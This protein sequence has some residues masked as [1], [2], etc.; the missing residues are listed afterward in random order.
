M[1]SFLNL[2]AEKTDKFINISKKINVS[3]EKTE[4]F[5][6]EE[7]Y[8]LEESYKRFVFEAR[9]VIFEWKD[10]YAQG[11]YKKH[12][13]CWNDI[14]VYKELAELYIKEEKLYLAALTY[15][16]AGLHE[17]YNKVKDLRNNTKDNEFAILA[18]R[19][20]EKYKKKYK[21]KKA[22]ANTMMSLGPIIAGVGFG[23]LIH[24]L[25]G[26]TNSKIAQFSL[27]L[28]GFSIL[29]GGTVVNLSAINSLDTSLSYRRISEEYK[30][31]NGTLPSEYYLYSGFDRET[32]KI[33]APSYRKH[34]GTLIGISVPLAA[35]AIYG[36]YEN[37]SFNFK[38]NDDDDNNS[39][40]LLSGITFFIQILTLAPSIAS[41]TG[42]IIMLVKASK[43]EKLNTEPSL[44]TL[45]SITPVID[46]V[47]KTYG[48]SMGFSF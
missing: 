36:L 18:K 17:E 40:L 15:K 39:S 10:K 24:D 5:D 46:P 11:L 29:A 1:I 34:G 8:P 20:S 28:G 6:K 33:S 22:V 3:A 32:K 42:G 41:L 9:Y 16:K 44:F 19:E 12:L 14:D 48:L 43:Y 7:C 31:D 45:N 47:S 38:N 25:A 13:R 26:G 2:F 37:Y 30:G 35:I 27:M 23:L 21:N 4:N